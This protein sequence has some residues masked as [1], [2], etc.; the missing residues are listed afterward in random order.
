MKKLF[1]VLILSLSVFHANSQIKG[2]PKFINKMYFDKD[3]T[4]HASFVV[5]PVL[6]SAPET[7]LEIGGAG[8]YSI[9]A[10][11]AGKAIPKFPISMAMQRSL[12]RAKA[13]LV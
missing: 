10:I 9:I 3:S 1:T 7:G 8:L 12:L 5:L 11:Q 4:K 13:V 2:L 6:S